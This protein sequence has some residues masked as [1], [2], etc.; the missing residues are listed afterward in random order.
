MMPPAFVI[1]SAT[2]LCLRQVPRFDESADQSALRFQSSR[3]A[4]RRGGERFTTACS[5]RQI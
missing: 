1:L 5:K 2:S 4:Q 3:P